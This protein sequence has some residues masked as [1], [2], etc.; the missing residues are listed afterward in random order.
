[1]YVGLRLDFCFEEFDMVEYDICQLGVGYGFSD[2]R[3]EILDDEC[4]LGWAQLCMNLA[5]LTVIW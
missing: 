3:L 4:K 5:R 1:M 2:G